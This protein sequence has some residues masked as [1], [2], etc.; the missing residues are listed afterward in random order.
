MLG[1]GGV[2]T[3]LT[4]LFWRWLTVSEVFLGR[5]AGT[6]YSYVADPPFSPSLISLVVSIDVKHHDCYYYSDAGMQYMVGPDWL[7]LFD[8]VIVNARKPKF[9]HAGNRWVM[10]STRRIRLLFF[11]H[12][13][14]YSP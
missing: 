11:L 8:I 3:F 10:S 7:D 12:I 14:F 4:L 5:S 13:F 1:T 6:S 2:P 9:F